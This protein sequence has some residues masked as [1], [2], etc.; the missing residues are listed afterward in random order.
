MVEFR[1]IL[2]TLAHIEYYFFTEQPSQPTVALYGEEEE[3]VLP[4]G[5]N[6]IKL[7]LPQ[8]DDGKIVKQLIECT[9]ILVIS[10]RLQDLLSLQKFELD[11]L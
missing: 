4:P 11:E 6:I 2:V 1:Q 5:T 10:W 3:E 7:F 8:P 9:N